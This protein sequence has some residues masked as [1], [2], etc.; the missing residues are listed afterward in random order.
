[1]DVDRNSSAIVDDLDRIIGVNRYLDVRRVTRQCLIDR[2]VDY[3]VNQVV[4]TSRG[5]A[6]DVHAGTFAYCLETF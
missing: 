4:E 3:F 5:R 1:M 2:V 6:P